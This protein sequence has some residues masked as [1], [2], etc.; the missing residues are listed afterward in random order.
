MIVTKALIKKAIWEF[1]FGDFGLDEAEM[2]K[3]DPGATEWIDKLAEKIHNR[4]AGAGE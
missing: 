3:E 4:M 2:T 1:D